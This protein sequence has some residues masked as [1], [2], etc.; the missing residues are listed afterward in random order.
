MTAPSGGQSGGQTR[1]A[2]GAPNTSNGVGSLHALG[3]CPGRWSETCKKPLTKVFAGKL[4]EREATSNL[5]LL[6]H[7]AVTRVT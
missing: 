2:E 6:K 3:L 5:V 1:E 4:A 7:V